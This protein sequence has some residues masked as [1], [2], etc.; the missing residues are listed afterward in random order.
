MITRVFFVR[1]AQPEHAWNDDRTRP[2]TSEG[3]E[4]SK[5]VAEIFSEVHIDYF[6]S[7]PYKRSID[8]IKEAAGTR[9]MKI[10]TDEKLREREKGQ[11]G[12]EFGMFQKRWDNLDY[13]E[14][15]GESIRMV[16]KRNIEVLLDILKKHENK[17]IVVATHGTALSSILNYFEPSFCCNDFLRIIDFMP[18]IIRL[19]FNGIELMGNEEL[20]II[21]KD[22]K[23]SNR[24]D[25][26]GSN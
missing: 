17:N 4:D 7:S 25:L 18:Y 6:Y 13:H 9:N 12:N 20:L 21:E 2:L 3:L 26:K 1:H 16:Q 5:R 10:M 22:Y 19:D 23:G 24:A 14:A 11:G 8:T 15:G